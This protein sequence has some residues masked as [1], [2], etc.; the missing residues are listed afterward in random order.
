MVDI[1][2]PTFR[3]PIPR[4]LPP[5]P[6]EPLEISHPLVSHPR[7]SVEYGSQLEHVGNQNAPRGSN[8]RGNRRPK[9]Q[10]VV[11]TTQ[12]YDNRSYSCSWGHGETIEANGRVGYGNYV[13][14]AN[15]K[16]DPRFGDRRN[17]CG[18]PAEYNGSRI[19]YQYEKKRMNLGGHRHSISWKP[20]VIEQSKP[21]GSAQ[22]QKFKVEWVA[23]TRRQDENHKLEMGDNSQQEVKDGDV[24]QIQTCNHLNRRKCEL[25]GNNL[26]IEESYVED[27]LSCLLP[28]AFEDWNSSG[29]E[30]EGHK[31]TEGLSSQGGAS[32]DDALPVEQSDS[33]MLKGDHDKKNVKRH[34]RTPLVEVYHEFL[35]TNIIWKY[36]PFF[37]GYSHALWLSL[38]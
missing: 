38:L 2:V 25:E 6:W 8:S 19:R 34:F 23:V 26:P 10:N 27:H 11:S 16:V 12:K 7:C 37:C 1:R 5:G 13:S 14:G 21:Q 24:L 32:Q 31:E 18:D 22:K 4:D 36:Y 30:S 3:V 28:E 35:I 15:A 9:H 17:A 33:L 20:K 29:V